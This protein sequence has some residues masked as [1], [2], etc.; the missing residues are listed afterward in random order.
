MLRSIVRYVA[1]RSTARRPPYH[2]LAAPATDEET[3]HELLDDK[4]AVERRDNYCE[5]IEDQNLTKRFSIRC[6]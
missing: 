4:L 3:S 2:L 5:N 1:V 6:Y